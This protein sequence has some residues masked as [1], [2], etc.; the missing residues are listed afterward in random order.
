MKNV[1]L[2][3]SFLFL[4]QTAIAVAQSP[5]YKTK[6]IIWFT[7]NG[8]NKIN[9]LAVGIQALNVED[10]MLVINGL[11]ADGGMGGMLALPYLL[12]NTLAP[13]K[14][15]IKDFLVVDTAKTFINGLS[16]SAGG[17]F[18]ISV[19]GVNI[20]GGITSAA[21][22][23]GLSVTGI[24]T[25]C[26]SFKGVCITGVKNI[27]K[28]GAGLQIGLFNYCK[29][30]KGLQIGLWNKSGKRGLPFINWGT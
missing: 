2:C 15:K 8:V 18:V 23:N 11:N 20:A 21:D 6:N 3:L 26:N 7:P 16:I 25:K 10:E 27:A 22:L 1:K 17:E 9:G 29:N 12:G 5:N 30:L 13:K 24:Y 28:K 19:N 14:N 4:F